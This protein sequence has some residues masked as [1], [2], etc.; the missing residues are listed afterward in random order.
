MNLCERGEGNLPCRE[1]DSR[2]VW[3]IEN[4]GRIPHALD[5]DGT[6]VGTRQWYDSG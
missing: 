6:V 3:C 4:G 5:A 2:E 1:L